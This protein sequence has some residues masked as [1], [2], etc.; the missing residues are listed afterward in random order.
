LPTVSRMLPDLS[1]G[2]ASLAIFSMVEEEEEEEELILLVE[3]EE[4]VMMLL[5][6]AVG[7]MTDFNR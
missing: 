5:R 3:E 6:R 1:D 4:K 7:M 2:R